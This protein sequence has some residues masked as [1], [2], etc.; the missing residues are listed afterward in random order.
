[1]KPIDEWN[2][3]EKLN[4]LE[5]YIESEDKFFNDYIKELT[6]LLKDND[7]DVRAQT[8]DALW[9]VPDENYLNKLRELSEKSTDERRYALEALG[10]LDDEEIDGLIQQA[11]ES[12]NSLLK[13][14]ALFAMGRSGRIKWKD[15]V[16]KEF[17]N[18]NKDIQLGAIKAAGELGMKEAGDDLLSFTYSKDKDIMEEAVW[19]LGKT[20]YSEAYE[21]LDELIMSSNKKLREL[22]EAAMDEWYIASENYDDELEDDEWYDDE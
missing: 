6:Y 9:D 2:K 4:F 7:A 13:I 11:Y 5:K 16:L 17:H 22:A 15:I 21:R 14:S 3:K 8:V 1:M 12:D 20:G 18:T 19:S 10:F